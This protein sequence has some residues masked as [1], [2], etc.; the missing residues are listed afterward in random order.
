MVEI[1]NL[2]LAET[3]EINPGTFTFDRHERRGAVRHVASRRLAPGVYGD[4]ALEP[5]SCLPSRNL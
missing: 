1:M 3:G 4:A 5:N 2:S